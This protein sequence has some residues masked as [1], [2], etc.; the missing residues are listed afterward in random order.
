ML[1]CGP[2]EEDPGKDSMLLITFVLHYHYIVLGYT[3]KF[4]A[5]CIFSQV[6]STS[7]N[8]NKYDVFLCCSLVSYWKH[9][10]KNLSINMLFYSK[11][12]LCTAANSN[13][14]AVF[15]PTRPPLLGKCASLFPARSLSLMWLLSSGTTSG[16]L[17]SWETDSLERW[18]IVCA[19]RVKPWACGP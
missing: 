18:V 15:K 1:H 9:C 2:C 3:G 7:N 17:S 6:C 13:N 5:V 11:Y 16:C 10:V 12:P 14:S 4:V 8:G 19:P